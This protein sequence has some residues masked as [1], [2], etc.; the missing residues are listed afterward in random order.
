MDV[1]RVG[2]GERTYLTEEV[3][4][5]LEELQKPLWCENWGGE[6][7]RNEAGKEVR[8]QNMKGCVAMNGLISMHEK[9]RPVR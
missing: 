1:L 3:P 9:L 5:A 7:F 6:L 4:E 8:S 2:K